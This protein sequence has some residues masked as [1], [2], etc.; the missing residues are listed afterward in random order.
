VDAFPYFWATSIVT[1]DSVQKSFFDVF[2]CLSI[3]LL[4]GKVFI[5]HYHTT[6]ILRPFYPGPSSEK[7]PEENSGF[8]GAREG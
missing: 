4:S 7:V 1:V 5:N 6:T 2:V 3:T 8:Y